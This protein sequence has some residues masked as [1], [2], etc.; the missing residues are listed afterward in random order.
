MWAKYYQD[1]QKHEIIGQQEKQK[2][3]V[4]PGKDNEQQVFFLNFRQILK[5]ITYVI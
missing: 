2:Q 1:K 4:F 3:V 5:V